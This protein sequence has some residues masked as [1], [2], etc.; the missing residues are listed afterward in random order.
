[1]CGLCATDEKERANARAYAQEF[2]N[3]LRRLATTYDAVASG[4]VKPHTKEFAEGTRNAHYI[5]RE[6]VNE[7]L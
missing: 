4:R 1:M 3:S 5:L 7:L 2:A 6:I